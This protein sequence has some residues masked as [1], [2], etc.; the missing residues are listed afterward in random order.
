MFLPLWQVALFEFQLT[1]KINM[2]T[3]MILNTVSD[4]SVRWNISIFLQSFWVDMERK[5]LQN[6]VSDFVQLFEKEL[7]AL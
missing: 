3:K 4:K 6:G 2:E 7:F 5:T 1:G